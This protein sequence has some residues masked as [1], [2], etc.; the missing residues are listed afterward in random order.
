ML[1]EFRSGASRGEA[2]WVEYFDESYSYALVL[3]RKH[4]EAEDLIQETYFRS[5][6]AIEDCEWTAT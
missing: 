6:P 1:R 5:M 4:A 2:P 3:T